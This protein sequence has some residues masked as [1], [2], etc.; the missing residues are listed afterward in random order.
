MK[1]LFLAL[2]LMLGLLLG[3]PLEAARNT[4]D[5]A[6]GS[7]LVSDFKIPKDWKL[8]SVQGTTLWF[9]DQKNE[10][11]IVHGELV[12]AAPFFQKNFMSKISVQ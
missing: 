1:K 5:S 6:L 8:V 4:N 12:G 10:I 9:Q 2:S 3:F 7:Y 11:Y